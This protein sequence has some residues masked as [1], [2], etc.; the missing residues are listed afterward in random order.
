[1]KTLI[2][3]AILPIVLIVAVALW[4]SESR[5]QRIRRLH[6]AGESQVSIAN[7]FGISRYQ[8]RKALA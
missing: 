1:M 8:V 5:E 6:R 4:A 7:R 3:W 2:W